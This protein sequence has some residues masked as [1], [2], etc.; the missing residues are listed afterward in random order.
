MTV[1]YIGTMTTRQYTKKERNN[2]SIVII[3]LFYLMCGKKEEEENFDFL[4]NRRA[5]V[6][7]VSLW[8]VLRPSPFS[9]WQKGVTHT[10]KMPT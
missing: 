1:I 2:P 8:I 10:Q 5:L 7:L 4:I 3:V 9:S 6:K